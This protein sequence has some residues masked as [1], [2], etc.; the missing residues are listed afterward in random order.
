MKPQQA[1]RGAAD[2]E[3]DVGDVSD[4]VAPS[5][6]LLAGSVVDRI[7]SVLA[8]F[9]PGQT[10]TLADLARRTEIPKGSLHRLLQQ[11]SAKGVVERT[12]N[13]YRLSLSMIDLGMVAL[14]SHIDLGMAMPVLRALRTS[15][16]ATV[17]LGV[18]H[19]RDVMYLAKVETADVSTPTEP[20]MK[21]PANC[22][23]LGKA[24]LA[25]APNAALRSFLSRPLTS[26]TAYSIRDGSALMS[27]LGEVREKGV[28]IECEEGAMGI[29][30]I[31]APLLDRSGSPLAA[32]SLTMPTKRFENGAIS[33]KAALLQRAVRELDRAVP[34]AATPVAS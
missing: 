6:D 25:Y 12:A 27:A 1:A 15:T 26:R 13:D 14:W 28:A 31:A 20:G 10:M 33:H 3:T 29:A 34:R 19:G 22:S 5:R 30:C 24:L 21:Q 18:L 9:T 8:E 11:L 2:V 7:F 32:V 4:D 23:S 17:H 16:S